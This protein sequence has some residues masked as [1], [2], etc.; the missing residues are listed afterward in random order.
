[1]SI[2]LNEGQD[3]KGKRKIKRAC[4]QHKPVSVLRIRWSFVGKQELLFITSKDAVWFRFLVL[5]LLPSLLQL[6]VGSVLGCYLI[7]DY[8]SQEVPSRSL[9][10]RMFPSYVCILA[11][12]LFNKTSPTSASARNKTASMSN[13]RL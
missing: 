8:L 4:S 10:S 7:C 12:S 6:W 9:Q 3:G 13:H 11:H 5:F 1:M 2:Y